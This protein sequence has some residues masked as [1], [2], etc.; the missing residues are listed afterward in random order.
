MYVP[1]SATYESTLEVWFFAYS[2]N[3]NTFNFKKMTINWDLHNKIEVYVKGGELK[4][5][6]YALS[7]NSKEGLY[8]ESI[9]QDILGYKW[10]LLR[11]GSE[12]ISRNPKYFFNSSR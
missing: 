5:K 8:T 4:A 10:N 12:F 7:D 1:S 6:C 3:F 9:E 2:Y 11:C